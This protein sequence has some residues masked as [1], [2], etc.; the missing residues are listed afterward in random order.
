VTRLEAQDYC[1]YRNEQTE[2]NGTDAV[3]EIER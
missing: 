2:K 3:E 1:D